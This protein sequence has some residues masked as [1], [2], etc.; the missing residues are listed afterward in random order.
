[1]ATTI[2]TGPYLGFTFAELEEELTRYKNEVKASG[3]RIVGASVNGQSFQFGNREGTLE[4]WSANL[5]A[6]LYYLRP[7]K[8][9]YAAPTDRAAVRFV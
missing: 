1:M 9:P 4:E 7:D 6:A 8:Y 3:T 5:Q 2:P